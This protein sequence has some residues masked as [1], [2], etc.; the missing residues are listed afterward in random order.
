MNYVVRRTLTTKSERKFHNVDLK[1]LTSH[2]EGLAKF[3]KLLETAANIPVRKSRSPKQRLT[4]AKLSAT[5]IYPAA[6]VALWS[7]L[8]TI[9]DTI[10]RPQKQVYSLADG[11]AEVRSTIDVFFKMT[12]TKKDAQQKKFPEMKQIFH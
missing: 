12:S 2:P 6:P 11:T 5:A 10:M 7:H 8:L 3:D 1:F 9:E 4:M